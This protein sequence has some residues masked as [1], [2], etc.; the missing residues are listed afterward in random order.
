MCRVLQGEKKPKLIG[1]VCVSNQHFYSWHQVL[2]TCINSTLMNIWKLTGDQVL[3]PILHLCRNHRGGKLRFTSHNHINSFSCL[4]DRFGPGLV[5]Y[6]YGFIEEL[7]C[8]RER[9][10][11]LKDCFPTDIVTLRH[12]MAQR[13][14]WEEEV[15]PEAILLSC[16]INWW[17]HLPWTS[18]ELL[19]PALMLPPLY[20]NIARVSVLLQTAV[21]IGQKRQTQPTH[22]QHFCLCQT[23]SF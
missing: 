12:S 20:T 23:A 10:I 22:Y 9:G 4:L 15:N 14:C 18:A 11:L 8:H 3:S 13:W 5:I 16:S 2:M 19:L 1:I 21:A 6:W 7:D 17:Q